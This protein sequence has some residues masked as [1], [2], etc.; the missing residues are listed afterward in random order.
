MVDKVNMYLATRYRGFRKGCG[1]HME[2]LALAGEDGEEKEETARP[3]GESMMRE[4]NVTASRL[5]TVGLRNALKRMHKPC[6]IHIMADCMYLVN[7]INNGW[8]EQWKQHDFMSSGKPVKNA[9]VWKE[10][11][12]MMEQHEIEIEYNKGTKYY[13]W[14]QS[15]MKRMEEQDE[16]IATSQTKE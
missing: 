5:A 7:C 10:I 13:G 14:Q 3:S 15:E 11:A 16:R 6:S 1:Y 4:E 9:E 8:M 2:V 12:G